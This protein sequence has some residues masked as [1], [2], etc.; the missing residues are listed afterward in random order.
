[1]S[2]N[3]C[4][5][6]SRSGAYNALP[7]FSSAV[8]VTLALATAIHTDWHF[9]RPAHH[10]LSLGLSWNWVLAIPVFALVAR[11][12]SRAWRDAAGRASVAIV[13]SA[14][15]LAGLIEPAWEYFIGGATFEW[16]FGAARTTGLAAYVATGVAAYVIVLLFTTRRP[17]TMSS[18]V[19]GRVRSSV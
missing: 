3:S 13:G 17:K 14:I 19:G 7:K 10:P 4:P 8:F 15:L 6:R 2:L 12:V 11:Y 1:M 18:E 5:G 16:A 9:A